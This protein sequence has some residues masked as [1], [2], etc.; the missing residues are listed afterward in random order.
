MATSVTIHQWLNFH[1]VLA[2]FLIWTWNG[3]FGYGDV[4]NSVCVDISFLNF[5]ICYELSL[6]CSYISFLNYFIC[7]DL[8]L[9]LFYMYSARFLCFR[10][11]DFSTFLFDKSE[12][13]FFLKL[14]VL[15]W[16]CLKLREYVAFSWYGSIPCILCVLIETQYTVLC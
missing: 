3:D 15:W 8:S 10:E 4:V 14:L 6:N 16:I 13:N 9:M 7:Y 1:D 11:S 12:V 5:F 2:E